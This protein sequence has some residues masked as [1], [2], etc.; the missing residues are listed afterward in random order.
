MGG[1]TAYLGDHVLFLCLLQ[2]GLDRILGE[3]KSLALLARAIDPTQSAMM[4]DVVKLLS[5]ICIVGEEN[6]YVV[7]SF[8]LSFPSL[9]CLSNAER[10]FFYFLSHKTKTLFY[11]QLESKAYKIKAANNLQKTELP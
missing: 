11:Y 3:E 5:A 8:I 4:T 7:A 6:T 10:L 9:Y 2:Y 1:I